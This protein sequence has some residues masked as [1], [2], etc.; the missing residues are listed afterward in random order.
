[1]ETE[2]YFV[3]TAVGL[4]VRRQLAGQ[5]DTTLGAQ[6][7]NYAYQALQ[8]PVFD[9]DVPRIDIT[10]TYSGDVGYRVGRKARVGVGLSYSARESNQVS[11][12]GY[13]RVRFGFTVNYGF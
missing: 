13:S 10:Y 3:S 2:P 1:M 4:Q 6:R 7:F 9:G 11:E 12:I 8:V 5:F